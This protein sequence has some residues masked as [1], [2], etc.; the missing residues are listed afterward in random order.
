MIIEVRLY[1]RYD[2]D[3]VTL[4][5]AGYPI[6]SMIKK[7]VTAYANDKQVCFDVP[8]GPYD[9]NERKTFRTRFVVNKKDKATYTLLTSIKHGY[10][11]AFCKMVLRNALSQQ[12]LTC[13]IADPALFTH[14]EADRNNRT[15]TPT[16][17][18]EKKQPIQLPK[19]S[20]KPADPP[21]WAEQ[22]TKPEPVAVPQK[23]TALHQN[24]EVDLMSMFES[25]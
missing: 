18:S 9:F 24:E 22:K 11:N 20:V 12:N 2:A 4:A 19:P 7:A 5:A 23:T 25:I 8:D 13:Y 10:R 17:I 1:K 16:V 14:Q 3:L 21:K 15:A 6:A